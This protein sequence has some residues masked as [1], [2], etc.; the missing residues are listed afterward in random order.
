VGR[1]FRGFCEDI[2]VA[3][4][5]GH[6]KLF[7]DIANEDLAARRAE[8]DELK[9]WLDLYAV[10]GI[11]TAVLHPGRWDMMAGKAMS[12]QSLAANVESLRELLAH[13]DGGPT[14]ICL[15]NGHSAA[16]LNRLI[17]G[18]GRTGLGICFD[19]GHLN[20]AL[21]KS[22][23]TAESFGGFVAE[24]GARLKALHLADNDGS[25][26]QH[27]MPCERGTVDWSAVMRGLADIGFDGPLNYEIP[28][29]IKCSAEERL[30]KLDRLAGVTEEL[31]AQAG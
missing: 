11:E 29:E 12:D 6:L 21:T 18:V 25:G 10:L 3:V 19:T 20:V 15:E 2:G 27:L 4:P 16:E 23:E 28:G 8:L 7:A 9:H 26:D 5:Q 30:E 31:I 14:T 17:D 24:A 1:A 13:A 22:P